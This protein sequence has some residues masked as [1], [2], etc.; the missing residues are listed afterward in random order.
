MFFYLL[1]NRSLAETRDQAS[2]N[3]ADLCACLNTHIGMV[4]RTFIL[5]VTGGWGKK[6]SQDGTLLNIFAEIIISKSC[7]L[8]SCDHLT[9]LSQHHFNIV[10]L[11]EKKLLGRSLQ[12]KPVKYQTLTLVKILMNM[13][14]VARLNRNIQVKLKFTVQNTQVS[15]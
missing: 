5:G 13:V 7:S 3:L 8:C 4:S 15:S 11:F 12:G 2:G 14:V 6:G 10:F 9:L 1:P